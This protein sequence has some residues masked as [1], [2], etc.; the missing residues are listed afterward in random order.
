MKLKKFNVQ[1]GG[2]IIYYIIY[3][4]FM[5]KKKLRYQPPKQR[6]FLMFFQEGVQ[7]VEN[8]RISWLFS[9]PEMSRILK[10]PSQFY[11]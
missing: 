10:M 7:R 1:Q 4:I 6:A 2:L 3:L 9:V 8:L 5:E 11:K